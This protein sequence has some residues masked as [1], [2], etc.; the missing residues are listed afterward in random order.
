MATT[1][2][3][4]FG[5]TEHTAARLAIVIHQGDDY[6]EKWHFV[7]RHLQADGT[8]MRQPIDLS[9]VVF[10]S[11]IVNG[12]KRPVGSFQILDHDDQGV[13]SVLLP[14]SDTDTLPP[15]TYRYWVDGADFGTGV[16]RTYASHTLEIL[17]K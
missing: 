2:P 4:R 7:S 17:P 8:Y 16:R 6:S 12:E 15:G 14:G 13:L 11:L 9:N 3:D 10:D 5:V 1:H